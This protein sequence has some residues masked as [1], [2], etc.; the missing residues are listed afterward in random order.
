MHRA[1]E[2]A[3]D[4]FIVRHQRLLHDRVRQWRVTLADVEDCISDV[5][6]DIAVLI[7]NGRIRPTRSLA[8]YVVKAFRVQLARR[9]KVDGDRRQAEYEAAEEADGVGERA[10]AATVSEGTLRA[11]RGVEWEPLSLPPAILR[12]ATMLD[13]GISDEERRI[14][15][16]LSNLV[17]QRDI[18]E[19]LGTSYAAGT[20]RIWRLRER[21][22]SAAKQ[23]A[24]HFDAH[25]QIELDR[26]FRRLE[27]SGQLQA[28]GRRRSEP[29][30]KGE[31]D[32]GA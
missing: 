7:V 6:E 23:H 16:W 2:D 13:E 3:I 32:D 14:L 8:G 18:C 1:D 5:I 28:G 15:T 19:W 17:P 29:S 27:R 12:L 10:I 11:S 26:F 21:L 20:Q 25:Q 9:S 24:T 22:R 4:E 31:F 30:T